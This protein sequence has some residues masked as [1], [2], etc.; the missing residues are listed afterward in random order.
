MKILSSPCYTIL[1]AVRKIIWI[2]K[3]HRRF[4]F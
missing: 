2:W 1:Y 4:N 3:V